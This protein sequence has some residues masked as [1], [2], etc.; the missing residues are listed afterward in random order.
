MSLFDFES[1]VGAPGESGVGGPSEGAALPVGCE[2]F[3]VL[4][5]IAWPFLQGDR[6]RLYRS[7][8]AYGA[9][10]R[11]G[12]RTVFGLPLHW[13]IAGLPICSVV[14]QF[15]NSIDETRETKQAT[16]ERRRPEC[17]VMAGTT[18][19]WCI[20]RSRQIDAIE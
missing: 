15:V 9:A 13:S 17:I 12:Q 6:D 19:F 20:K 18:G 11:D 10:K 3:D 1:V 16:T 14:G 5:V 8:L 7:R 4:E 2:N